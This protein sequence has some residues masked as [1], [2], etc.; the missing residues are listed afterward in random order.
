MTLVDT[1]AF[2]ASQ[3]V[4]QQLAPLLFVVFLPILVIFTHRH[5]L[6]IFSS[7]FDAARMVLESLGLNFL[8]NRSSSSQS[9]RDSGSDRKKIKKK[10]RTR[11]EQ[12]TQYG[13]GMCSTR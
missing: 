6:D 1:L 8:W 9:S 13:V 11:A 3:P 5:V 7:V 4:I 12:V 2:L 10:P